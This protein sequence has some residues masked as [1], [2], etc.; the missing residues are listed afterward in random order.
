MK[1]EIGDILEYQINETKYKCMVVGFSQPNIVYIF[2]ILGCNTWN[3]DINDLSIEYIK[4]GHIDL[5]LLI[6]E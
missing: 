3:E 2:S 5:S 6:G 4:I 1:F